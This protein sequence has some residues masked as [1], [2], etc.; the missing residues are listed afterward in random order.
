MVKLEVFVASP[1]DVQSERELLVGVVDEINELAETTG[2]ILNL[3]RWEKDVRPG[4]A[5]DPQEVVNRQ[6]HAADIT[7][8]V[9]WKRLGTPTNRASSG[10]VEEF[11]RAVEEAL[12]D[13][14]REVFTYFKTALINLHKDDL[15]QA[16]SVKS[17][18]GAIDATT[19]AFEFRTA[20]EFR[21]LVSRHLIDSVLDRAAQH[22][23]LPPEGQDADADF[24]RGLLAK[25]NG[26]PADAIRSWQLAAA[27]DHRG[28]VF[29]LAMT[30]REQ[31]KLDDADKWFRRASED[32]NATAAYNVGLRLRERKDPDGAEPWLRRGAE[33]GD[34]SSMYNLGMVLKS[35]GDKDQAERWL[36]RGA[37]GGDVQAM[38]NAGLLRKE[39]RDR[40]GAEI[41]FR[42][43]AEG[44][45][46]AAMYDL[47]RLLQQDGYTDEEATTWLDRARERGHP[48][49]F[50]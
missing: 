33:G 15:A 39:A 42:R 46:V 6:V 14:R 25:R 27:Q 38:Y 40:E 47:G 1:S 30:L 28:A 10:T 3:A 17:F 7:I 5:D 35:K 31:G 8:V 4:V 49:P 26:N 44:G 11:Q 2:H 36:L 37:E 12:S 48:G 23:Q 24:V 20:A 41:W 9:F 34:V 19:L 50:E 43:G 45:D 18:R 29:E 16:S 21:A 22:V 32:G 13:P